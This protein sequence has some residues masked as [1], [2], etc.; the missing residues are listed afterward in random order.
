MIVYLTRKRPEFR[1]LTQTGCY[2]HHKVAFIKIH[3]VGGTSV[4][5]VIQRF[6]ETNRLLAAVPNKRNVFG[7]EMKNVV[8]I[9]E[10]LSFDLVYSH[11]QYFNRSAV[12][13]IMPQTSVYFTIVR[14]PLRQL[15]SSF[16]YYKH[17]WR[18][19][20]LNKI[21]KDDKEFVDYLLHADKYEPSDVRDSY[22][23]NRMSYDLGLAEADFRNKTA[24]ERWLR[25]LDTELD[26]VLITER[27]N[28]SLVMLRRRLCWSLR[29]ILYVIK[30]VNH[31]KRKVHL[32]PKV[33][34]VYRNRYMADIML[35]NYSY[36]RFQRDIQRQSPDF[37]D[38]VSVF[39]KMLNQVADYCSLAYKPKILL[40]PNSRFDKTPFSPEF[41]LTP[42]EC[43][44]MYL[45]ELEFAK[46]T[47]KKQEGV[48]FLDELAR[49]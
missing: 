17:V 23:N 45:S 40:L 14:E 31:R 46:R 27:F 8:K 33:L 30:N 34:T 28:E 25:K 42:W 41:E 7:K 22:T 47:R 29:D 36:A 48:A 18:F 21:P 26:F 35:Y 9:P 38:E 12:E 20:Y 43:E 39:E 44:M 6:G 5:N 10:K 24:I 49:H 2:P 13:R 32:S 16:Y 4:Q 1:P 37:Q 11:M 15:I 3:K 19:A